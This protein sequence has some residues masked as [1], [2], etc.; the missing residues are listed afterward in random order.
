M[1]IHTYIV[2]PSDFLFEAFNLTDFLRVL[3]HLSLTTEMLLLFLTFCRTS[4][5]AFGLKKDLKKDII[6]ES[7]LQTYFLVFKNL[8][9]LF[10]VRLS[11]CQPVAATRPVQAELW[12]ELKPGQ[13]ALKAV[14]KFGRQLICSFQPKIYV[15]YKVSRILQNPW[16]LDSIFFNITVRLLH[17]YVSQRIV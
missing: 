16:N 2:L 13:I 4:F 8:R 7:I 14:S 12:T 10:V 6:F 5:I 1:T 17:C 11:R 9:L 15:W 3:S